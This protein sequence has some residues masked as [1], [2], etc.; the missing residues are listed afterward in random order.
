MAHEAVKISS[1]YDSGRYSH[2]VRAGNTLYISGQV[3]WDSEGNVVGKGDFETQARQAY[4]NL[5][6]VLKDAGASMANL[7]KVNM[8]LTDS[9]FAEPNRKLRGEF[10]KA[11]L[12]AM[13]LVIVEGLALPELLFE[14]EGVAV[15]D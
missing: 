6:A 12:P 2:V 3:G 14:V 10:F 1:V 13:T 11:P 5:E 7:V 15:V 9:R 8:Y 4:R